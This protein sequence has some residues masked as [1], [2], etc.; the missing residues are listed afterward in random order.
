MKQDFWQAVLSR[1]D[2]SF[3]DFLIDAY[4]DGGKSS[5]F[6][7][8]AKIHNINADFYGSAT[9]NL[10]ENLPWDFIELKHPPKS[11]LKKEFCDIVNK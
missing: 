10:D 2:G 4:K 7:K 3:T 6:K 8:S 11:F 5:S 9:W 1:G